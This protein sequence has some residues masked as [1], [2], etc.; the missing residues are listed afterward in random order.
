MTSGGKVQVESKD[1][2][3]KRLGRSTDSGD[4]VVQAFW[5]EP[6]P[7]YPPFRIARIS[8]SGLRRQRPARE[9]GRLTVGNTTYIFKA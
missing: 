7:T 1:E 8:R 3:R 5:V 4:A 6:A 9:R 2:I